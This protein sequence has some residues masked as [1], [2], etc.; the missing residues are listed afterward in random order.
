MASLPMV[1]EEFGIDPA[2]QENHFRLGGMSIFQA[3]VNV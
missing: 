1:P 3:L 2:T